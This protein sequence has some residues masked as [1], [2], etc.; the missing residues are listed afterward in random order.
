MLLLRAEGMLIFLIS[1]E[2]LELE[3]VVTNA[4]SGRGPCE[5]CPAQDFDNCQHITPGYGALEASIIFVIEEPIS[6]IHWASH[7]P[8]E[9]IDAIV[10]HSSEWYHWKTLHEWFLDPLELS[11]RDIW[12][13]AAVKCP[14]QLPE[15]SS[16][17]FNTLRAFSNC[18]EYLRREVSQISPDVLVSLGNSA[19]R[20][21]LN[22]LGVEEVR[23]RESVK[24]LSFG[25]CPYDANPPVVMAPSL[26]ASPTNS[27]LIMV[28]EAIHDHLP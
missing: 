5:T 4:R 11:P 14:P 28:R 23:K 21:V 17:Q 18:S 9:P 1:M 8:W 19:T 2:R 12:I 22:V 10:E 20:W 25:T 6:G 26:T 7:P 3:W 27:D 15:Q 16:K 24:H 13:T